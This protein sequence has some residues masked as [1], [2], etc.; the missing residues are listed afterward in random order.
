MRLRR[1]DWGGGE[2]AIIL[3][4][5]SWAGGG[6]EGGGLNKRRKYSVSV[7]EGQWCKAIMNSSFRPNLKFGIPCFF[8]C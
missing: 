7:V 2:G 6:G 3:H 4:P 1:G 8:G 5:L